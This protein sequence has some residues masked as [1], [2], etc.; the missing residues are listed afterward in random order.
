[1]MPIQD[2]EMPSGI[3]EET[4]SVDRFL[5]IAKTTYVN[6]GIITLAFSHYPSN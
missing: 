6:L 2:R 1:M 5:P 4:I 3:H